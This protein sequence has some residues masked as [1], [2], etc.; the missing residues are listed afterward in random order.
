MIRNYDRPDPKAVV[1][2]VRKVLE[3]H[4]IDQLTKGA[5][6]F[7]ITHAGFIAHYD[8]E[9]FKDTYRRNLDV[10]VGNFLS[11]LGHGWDVF[12]NNSGSYLY[13]VSYRGVV[14]ADIIRELRALFV[15]WAPIV[16][17]EEASR[18]RAR[19]EQQLAQ[20]AQELGYELVKKGGD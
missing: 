6:G 11:Q 7:L 8:H 13:D 14:L 18:K 19:K 20:M 12:L 17:A 2:S 15:Q 16:N 1:R 10:F 9:G 3:K 4:D 5:Y